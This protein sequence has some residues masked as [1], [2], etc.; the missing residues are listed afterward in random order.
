M[1]LF[2]DRVLETTT[3]IGIGSINLEG[4]KTGY[5]SFSTAFISGDIVY[6]CI[7]GG[8]EWEVGIGTVTTGTPWSLSRTVILSSSNSNSI[9]TFSAGTKDVFCTA[10]AARIGAHGNDGNA[11]FFENDTNVT[12][13]YTIT[14]GRNAM[15]AG[16]ITIDDGVVVTIPSG[17]VWTIV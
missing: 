2:K 14:S 1:P 5:R 10:P 4:A 16:P 3:S 15:S 8:S 12:G 9:V 17:S 11:V 7:A 13:N 6:Y